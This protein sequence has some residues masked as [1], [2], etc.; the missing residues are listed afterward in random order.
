MPSSPTAVED[1]M[2]WGVDVN[3]ARYIDGTR[4]TLNGDQD[5]HTAELQH[6]YTDLGCTLQVHQPQR[7]DG[8]I[9]R[10][11]A[12]LEAQ[13]GCLIGCNSYIT[14]PGTQGLAPHYDDVDVFVCQTHGAKRWAVYASEVGGPAGPLTTKSSPD[15]DAEDLPD[16][17]LLDVVL[18]VGDV[19]Y[20]PRG[21]VHQARAL[22]GDKGVQKNK[23]A[24][25]KGK[26]QKK[27]HK[28][29][30]SGQQEDKGGNGQQGS[31]HLTL[32]AYQRWN[33]A[34]LTTTLL[35]CMMDNVT[36]GMAPTPMVLP[37]ALRK[38]LPV[39][40]VYEAGMQVGA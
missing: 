22:E 9:H 27:K 21:T 29:D 36:M 39:G 11:V 30:G 37:M 1:A 40:F 4:E 23:Q 16:A 38:G 34:T 32:S 25:G 20:M 31:S 35:Q 5:I 26:Q 24:K 19:L 10:I 2:Q 13:L 28:G 18:Q 17:P 3:A 7:W 33:Y 6:L 12:A 14:P 15:L 8:T